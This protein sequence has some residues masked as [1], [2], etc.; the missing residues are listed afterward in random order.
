MKSKKVVALIVLSIASMMTFAAQNPGSSVSAVPSRSIE[1]EI[2]GQKIL[3]ALM[4]KPSGPTVRMAFSSVPEKFEPG[5]K[6]FHEIIGAMI[7]AG[8]T[9]IPLSTESMAQKPDCNIRISM[10]SVRS[11]TTEL[12]LADASCGQRTDRGLT[13]IRAVNFGLDANLAKGAALFPD[14]ISQARDE[15]AKLGS[16]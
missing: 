11:H 9:H 7:A 14:L 6:L 8:Y 3:M 2:N 5:R 13:V 15:A 12:L 4:Q 10:A 16:R 1:T